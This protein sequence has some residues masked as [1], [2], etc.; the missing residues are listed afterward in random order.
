MADTPKVL[1]SRHVYAGR[2]FD[3]KV[4]EIE[5]ANGVQAQRETIRHPGAVGMVA[6]DNDGNII[7]VTQYRHAA[8]ERML[9]IPAGTLE[10]GED[11]DQAAIR[12]LQEEIGYRPGRIEPIGGFYVAPGYCDEFIRL[13]VCSELESSEA[14]KDEDEDIEVEVLPPTEVLARIDDGSITDAKTIIGVNRWARM[15]GLLRAT[16]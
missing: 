6:V 8:G 15:T 7:L 5:F 12:E 11:P 10:G 9:E 3:L 14:D 2:L 16:D 1:S 13:F 4:E